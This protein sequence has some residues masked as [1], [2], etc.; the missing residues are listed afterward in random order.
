MKRFRLLTA[1]LLAAL[2]LTGCSVSDFL[3]NLDTDQISDWLFSVTEVELDP[4]LT[5]GEIR[6]SLPEELSDITVGGTAL[7]CDT[8]HLAVK[9][10]DTDTTRQ[11]DEVLCEIEVS[12][13][14][15]TLRY[16]CSFYYTYTSSG[17]WGMTEWTIDSSSVDLEV[18]EGVLTEQLEETSI[19]SLEET[20]G[21][22]SVTY[23]S[24]SWNQ[25]TMV[26]SAVYDVD[27]E[28]GYV[29]TQGT[30]TIS[31]ALE[32]D[33]NSGLS[34]DW[35]VEVDE[36][37]VLYGLD[38]EDTTWIVEGSVDTTAIQL[39]VSVS[40]TDID[41]QTVTFSAVAAV[42]E[43]GDSSYYTR[44]T[45]ENTESY[46]VEDGLITF[47]FELTGYTWSCCF[48]AEDQWARMDGSYISSLKLNSKRYMDTDDLRELLD[49]DPDDE[50]EEALEYDIS[51]S[52]TTYSASDGTLIYEMQ[53]K[54][55]Q[56]SGSGVSSLNKAVQ[57]AVQS[58]L[59]SPQI[60]TDQDDLDALA[61]DAAE[62]NST[63]SLPWSDELTIS[64][65]YN[66]NHYLS[67]LFVYASQLEDGEITYSCESVSY[68]L[69]TMEELEDDE[70]F[71]GTSR[72]LGAVINSYAEEEL[73]SD[74]AVMSYV[75]A[76]VFDT[77]GLV[78]YL[79][80]DEETGECM[81][82]TVPYT[83]EICL[84]DPTAE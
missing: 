30:L 62:E 13:D 5:A 8:V 51:T 64:V 40:E 6:D 34:F 70:V 73:Y 67:L 39:A 28:S 31:A 50:E 21:T 15:I 77:D 53:V 27:A 55:P 1:A 3:N 68:D 11:T 19:S 12:G 25:S 10:R 52:S 47:S 79:L 81:T 59:G 78:F 69:T 65:V 74:A 72:T 29:L 80:A 4:V 49:E 71:S 7:G 35:D 61:E 58:F 23:Q 60:S 56:F 26:Y 36:S 54:Y 44:Y 22:G 42:M 57:A 9:E 2:L 84:I 17:G 45:E 41:E 16:L 48:D 37:S 20:Y 24:G 66:Q 18:T 82:V 83:E 14:G 38:L 33:L 63:L 46:T 75:Q 76:W 32:T 43:E